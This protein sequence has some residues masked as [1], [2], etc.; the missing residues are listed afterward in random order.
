MSPSCMGFK[1]PRPEKADTT[2]YH[3][4]GERTE[5]WRSSGNINPSQG[6]AIANEVED[7]GLKQL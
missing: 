4:L 3:G 1:E 5:S 6:L 2:L 7:N